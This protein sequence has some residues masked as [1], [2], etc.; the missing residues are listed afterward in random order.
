M[1]RIITLKFYLSTTYVYIIFLHIPKT[2]VIYNN[3]YANIWHS[4]NTHCPNIKPLTYKTVIT[5]IISARIAAAIFHT[6]TQLNKVRFMLIFAFTEYLPIV[7]Y[8]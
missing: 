6:A 3:H 2:Y 5:Y 4:C 7:N 1:Y 8:K